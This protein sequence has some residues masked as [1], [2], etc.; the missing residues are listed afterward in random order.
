MEED[1]LKRLIKNRKI[2]TRNKNRV[3][4]TM[5]QSSIRHNF[6]ISVIAIAIIF[7]IGLLPNGVQGKLTISKECGDLICKPHNYCSSVDHFCRPC[8]VACDPALGNYDKA[9]CEKDCQGMSMLKI[10]KLFANFIK[11]AFIFSRLS[12]RFVVH[13]ETR[14]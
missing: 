7:R 10:C 5:R 6:T 12:P 4:K 2:V 13:E 8:Q 9:V 11:F 1:S 3:I 14:E